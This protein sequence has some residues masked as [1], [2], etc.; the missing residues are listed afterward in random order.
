M[1]WEMR[2]PLTMR[3]ALERA[4]P[5]FR[6]WTVADYAE[7]IRR[8]YCFTMRET[9]WAIA[10][11]FDGDGAC[12]LVIDGHDAARSCRVCVWGAPGEPRVLLL[13]TARLDPKHPPLDSAL[14]FYGP[15][16]ISTNFNDSTLVLFTD[17]FND[18]V[19]EKAGVLY[20]WDK[21]HFAEFVTSD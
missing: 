13:A 18:Y 11:D 21:D 12:D 1:G 2:I 16:R 7:D 10:G 17:G 20:Y 9:P 19:W 4:V 8:D 5:G 14:Q 6:P 3:R 15:G